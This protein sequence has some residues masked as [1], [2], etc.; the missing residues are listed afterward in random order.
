MINPSQVQWEALKWVMKYLSG[1]L[2]G[3]LKYTMGAQKEYTLK[4]F[5]DVDYTGNMTTKKYLLGFMFAL[6][7]TTI[8]W[9]A[10]K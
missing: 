7:R 9:K 1:L 8:S 10:N 2:K 3:G 6:F 4:R 5:V